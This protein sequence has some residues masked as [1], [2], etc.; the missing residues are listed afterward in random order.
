MALLW[1]V[2]DFWFLPF[3]ELTANVRL[4]LLTL[5]FGSAPGDAKEENKQGCK[6]DHF[7]ARQNEH[8]AANNRSKWLGSPHDQRDQAL[9]LEALQG[10]LV[11]H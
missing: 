1:K 8:K 3:V 5:N 11:F 7:C 9:F 2:R 10:Y 4:F 6:S